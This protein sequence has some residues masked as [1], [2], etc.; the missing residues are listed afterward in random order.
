[1]EIPAD[2]TDYAD[3]GC[4]LIAACNIETPFGSTRF[5]GTVDH[6]LLGGRSRGKETLQL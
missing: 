4:G 2:Y 5:V 3:F 1:M 6:C